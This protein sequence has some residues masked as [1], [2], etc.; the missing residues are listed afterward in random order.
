VTQDR[1]FSGRKDSAEEAERAWVGSSDR[2]DA[3]V[4]L[5]QAPAL[6]PVADL[7][8]TEASTQK[9]PPRHNPVLSSSNP[10]NQHVR[11]LPLWSHNNQKGRHH[12]CSPPQCPPSPAGPAAPEARSAAES[13]SYAPRPRLVL[14]SITTGTP[15][16]L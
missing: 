2:V 10:S 5:E 7:P 15:S 14:K 16:S 1:S 13:R 9:L 6:Q 4:H 12:Q 3:P 8:G 11:C